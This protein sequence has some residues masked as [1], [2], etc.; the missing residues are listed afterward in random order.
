MTNKTLRET[1]GL[2]AYRAGVSVSKRE[3]VLAALET[4]AERGGPIS[5]AEVARVAGVSRQFIHSHPELH[6][7]LKVRDVRQAGI[8]IQIQS[9]S[10][11]LEAGRQADKSTLMSKVL[12][13]RT[14]IQSLSERVEQLEAAR[15]RRLGDQL[16]SLDEAPELDALELNVSL[17]RLRAANTK[18]QR[19]LDAATVLVRRL[20]DDLGGA[21]EALAQLLRP[22]LLEDQV[23]FIVDSERARSEL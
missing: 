22:A 13:Q 16:V 15:S 23:A 4:V 1:Q 10:A 17:E 19:E 12:R 8:R 9:N 2:K 7:K 6:Q 5:V 20:Q 21:R 3:A 11:R 18:L 14:T